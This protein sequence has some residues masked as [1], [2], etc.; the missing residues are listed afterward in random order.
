MTAYRKPRASSA[1][2]LGLFLL[3]A[4]LCFIALGGF[5][6]AQYAPELAAREFGPPSERLGA[7]QR[8]TLSI[9]LL[10]RRD[11]L[12]NAIRP[13]GEKVGFRIDPGESASG[14]AAMLEQ[15]G[16]IKNA[17]AFRSYLVYSGQD[18]TLQSGEYSLNPGMNALEIAAA[19]QDATPEEVEFNILAGWRVEEIAAALPTSGLNISPDAFLSAVS[20]PADFTLPPGWENSG[21]LEGFLMPGGYRFNRQ[22]SADN[23][24]A[25]FTRNFDEQVTEELKRGFTEQ[26]L[27]LREAVILASLVQREAIQADEQPMIASVFLNRLAAGMRLDSDPTVQY[28]LGLQEDSG[29]WW[30]VPLSAADLQVPSPYNTYQINGL[31]PGP[32]CNPGLGALRAVA[33]PAKSPYYYFRAACDG[34]GRH[35]FARTYEEQVQN[36]CP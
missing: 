35:N 15:A 3:L 28:A 4:F 21:S 30:K 2:P 36:A 5:L 7:T 10:F 20:A 34:S 31:P 13:G 27:G 33:F 25:T 18:T 22:S 29:S 16:L 17:D 12:L 9:Q 23:L 32:I 8:I 14:V 11:D 26:G 6:L 1:F 24:V 19:L